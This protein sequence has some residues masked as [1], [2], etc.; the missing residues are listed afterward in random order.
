MRAA[1]V[2]L[3]NGFSGRYNGRTSAVRFN[4]F[5]G[6]YLTLMSI[7]RRKRYEF[8]VIGL[9][10]KN[11]RTFERLYTQSVCKSGFGSLFKML[12]KAEAA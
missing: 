7:F 8:T 4:E 6:L 9:R 2:A 3:E 1:Y 11:Q 10:T 5:I 12:L